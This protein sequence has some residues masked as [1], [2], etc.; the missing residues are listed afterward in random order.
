MTTLREDI[1][2]VAVIAHVD[3]GKTTLVDS[4]LRQSGSL[5]ESAE[6]V[7]RM[8]DTGDLERERGITILAKNTSVN[9]LDTRINIL[10]TPG[11]HDFGIATQ[12]LLPSVDNRLDSR[13][14]KAVHRQRGTFQRDASLQ[15]DIA[16]AVKG[17]GTCLQCMP[18]HHMVH[19]L[20]S[21][22]RA[23]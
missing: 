1:R 4:M 6:V 17:V 21:N 11:H 3:H 18:H 7:E 14:T 20:R 13:T 2:N 23:C 8:M 16:R 9:Y 22:A 10:D 5:R 19:L 15:A 12:D